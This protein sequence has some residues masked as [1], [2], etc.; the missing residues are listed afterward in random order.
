MFENYAAND[1]FIEDNLQHNIDELSQLCKFQSV[2]AKN[3]QLPETAAFLSELFIKRGFTVKIFSDSGGPVV[4]AEKLGR[5]D[6]TLLF[7]NH[8]D[9]QPAE[10]LE[11]WETDPF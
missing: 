7:Y 5:I 9:V 2:S 8:Y 10:P 1:K 3:L 6:K 11:L 4:Y